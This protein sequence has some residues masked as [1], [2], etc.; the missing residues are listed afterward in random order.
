MR[1]KRNPLA[2][3]GAVLGVLLLLVCVG[4]VADAR[5][6][7]STVGNI[8]GTVRDPQGAAVRQTVHI[9]N[10]E[11]KRHDSMDERK[12]GPVTIAAFG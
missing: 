12:V 7:T 11:A 10:G 5:G 9:L 2:L 8:S 4:L 6:Q 1:S 3:K